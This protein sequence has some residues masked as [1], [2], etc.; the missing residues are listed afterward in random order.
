M[1][2]VLIGILAYVLVQL[3]I[4]VLV[5]RRIRGENDYLLAGRRFGV[6]LATFTIFA[7]WFG[8]E[9]CIGAAG[10]V[11]QGGLSGS[12]ADPFGS[13]GIFVTA[14]IGLFSRFGHVRAA[15]GALIA[16]IGTWITGD[17]LL[18]LAQ[19]YLASVAAALTAYIFLALTEHRLP[20]HATD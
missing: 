2:P 18:H 12:T 3:L 8:A 19:P 11:Y 15:Y 17:Y 13:A 1:S 6:G 5:A 4:V 7:T 20:R 10:A 14:V 16:G 9:T